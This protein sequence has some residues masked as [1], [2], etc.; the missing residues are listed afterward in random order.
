MKR[1]G[2]FILVLMLVLSLAA[3]S[4]S[5]GPESVV[6]QFCKA[7]EKGDVEILNELIQLNSS[8]M[9]KPRIFFDFYESDLGEDSYYAYCDYIYTKDEDISQYN[10][11]YYDDLV[12]QE[13][14]K[15]WCDDFAFEYG[16]YSVEY[17]NYEEEVC[18]P[19]AYIEMI[20]LCQ[21][22]GST[23]PKH[24]VD[25]FNTEEDE[26]T[27]YFDLIIRDNTKKGVFKVAVCME[28]YKSI[29]RWYIDRIY[30]PGSEWTSESYFLEDICEPSL[31]W[32]CNSVMYNY[33]Q[34]YG[35][36]YGVDYGSGE[37]Y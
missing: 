21:N 26:G 34:L 19:S 20:P 33:Q 31:K 18:G 4:S 17:I 8:I 32:Y 28:V 25:F 15:E 30:T 24:V 2:A 10:D 16:K 3:C 1:I 37:E 14:F 12:K 7:I 13:G 6:K 23:I 35:F 36:E 5:S 22:E 11:M 29:G 27:L 9:T